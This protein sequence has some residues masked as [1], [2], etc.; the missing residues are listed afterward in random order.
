MS[1]TRACP[2]GTKAV[3]AYIAAG[4]AVKR[5]S[6]RMQEGIGGTARAA[7]T[8]P[9]STANW[10]GGRPRDCDPKNERPA[11]QG[12]GL[13]VHTGVPVGVAEGLKCDPAVN[14]DWM[15]RS[16]SDA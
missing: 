1:D 12:R 10:K 8:A 6:C 3:I 15:R 9:S 7:R 14:L 16:S 13:A 5:L 4:V 11:P 2:D